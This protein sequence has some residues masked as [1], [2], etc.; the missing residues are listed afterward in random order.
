MEHS[1]RVQ[2]LEGALR[3]W[4]RRLFGAE[5]VRGMQVALLVATA[6]VLLCALARFVWP[7][8]PLWIIGAAAPAA[9]ALAALAYAVI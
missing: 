2:E 5:F 4:K 1:A 6:G 7:K 8:I 3:P 9:A